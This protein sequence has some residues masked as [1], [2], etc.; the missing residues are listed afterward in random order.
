MTNDIKAKVTDTARQ[1]APWKKGIPWWVVLIEGI[2]LLGLGFYMFFAKPTTLALLGWII[3]LAL[4]AGALSLFG[5]AGHRPTRHE[6]DA[7]PRRGGLGRGVLVI[8]FRLLGW[9]SV[10]RR[11]SS[12]AWAVWSTAAWASTRCSIKSSCRCGASPHRRHLLHDTGVLLTASSVWAH[13]SPQCRSSRCR[14]HRRRRPRP[15]S[16]ML[17]N[18]VAHLD[19][20]AHFTKEHHNGQQSNFSI[21]VDFGLFIRPRQRAHRFALAF[22]GFALGYSLVMWLGGGLDNN[23][24][25]I[26]AIVAGGILAAVFYLLVNFTLYLAGGILGLVLMMALL[27]LFQLSGLDLGIIGWILVAAATLAGGFFGPRLGTNLVV[28]AT[29]LAGAYLIVLGLSAMFVTGGDAGEPQGL[30]STSF[31]LVLFASFAVL[32]FMGQYQVARLRRRFLR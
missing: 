11:P 30:L 13:W 32:A 19:H 17:R 21:I 10:G 22:L 1:V 28:L 31:P 25:I 9:F 4:A 7:R 18:S 5:L 3:A 15:L 16:L 12:W 24:V 26:V 14:H 29:S 27:G 20:L 8:L 23:L 6:M 2:I